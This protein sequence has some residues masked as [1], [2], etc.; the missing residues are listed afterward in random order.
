[1]GVAFLIRGTNM[2]KL[3]VLLLCFSL[4]GCATVGRQVNQSNAEKLQKGITTKAEVIKIFG[5]PSSQSFNQAGK[6]VFTYIGCQVKNSAWNFIPVISAVHSE[7]KMT[8][9]ILSI[10]FKNDIVEEY[11]FTTSDTPIKYGII[12]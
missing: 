10:T 2:K 7:M 4:V 5:Q 11:N 8:N 12:P 6:V 3:K 9:Q 1:M